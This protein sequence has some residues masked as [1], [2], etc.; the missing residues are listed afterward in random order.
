MIWYD[1]VPWSQEQ[2][3]VSLPEQDR[4]YLPCY[5]QQQQDIG[6]QHSTVQD[7]DAV[8]ME[9]NGQ[10]WQDAAHYAQDSALHFVHHRQFPV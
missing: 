1:M 4:E 7:A 6:E 3:G 9:M 2:K 8:A 5:Q 10:Q